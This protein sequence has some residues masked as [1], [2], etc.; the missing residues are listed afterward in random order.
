MFR[1]Y[2]P[3]LHPIPTQP[4][5]SGHVIM[6]ASRFTAR[7]CPVNS[8][9]QHAAHGRGSVAACHALMREVDFEVQVTK[10]AEE[11]ADD[12]WPDDV[13]SEDVVSVSWIT[14]SRHTV[15]VAELRELQRKP[16]DKYQRWA[17]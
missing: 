16:A 13:G 7:N 8:L 12:E 9:V 11:L 17:G 10:R 2:R 6:A 4:G 14:V 5:S 1:P 15:P 3:M